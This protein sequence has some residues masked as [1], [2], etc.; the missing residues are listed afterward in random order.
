MFVCILKIAIVGV[1][2]AVNLLSQ[3]N[4]GYTFV[5]LICASAITAI[6]IAIVLAA[7]LY[8]KQTAYVANRQLN[9]VNNAYY[10]S[11]W[12]RQHVVATRCLDSSMQIFTNANKPIGFT[13]TLSA[14]SEGLQLAVGDA[15]KCNV[16]T[17]YVAKSSYNIDNLYWKNA[18]ERAI[19]LSDLI[20]QLRIDKYTDVLHI[21]I[22]FAIKLDTSVWEQQYYFAGKKY[23]VI[24][25]YLYLPWN[26]WINVR[27]E[28][29]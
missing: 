15:E 21:K 5:E 18:D 9:L 27:R 8:V 11:T 23:S 29:Q 17:L 26:I 16:A 6:L 22:L 13:T 28:K 12:L 7:L 1:S 4:A 25:N 10:V 3:K 2:V 14:N 19:A 20:K 24:D